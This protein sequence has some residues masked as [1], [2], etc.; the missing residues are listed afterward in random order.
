MVKFSNPYR[1]YAHLRQEASEY[2]IRRREARACRRFW[3]VTAVPEVTL[4]VWILLLGIICLLTHNNDGMSRIGWALSVCTLLIPMLLPH[5]LEREFVVPSGLII[6][7]TERGTVCRGI[8]VTIA[9]LYA[10]LGIWATVVSYSPFIIVGCLFALVLLGLYTYC[11][12]TR[13]FGLSVWG[14]LACSLSP[15]LASYLNMPLSGAVGIAILAFGIVATISG[16]RAFLKPYLDMADAQMDEAGGADPLLLTNEWFSPEE[17][18]RALHSHDADIRYM[19]CDFLCS[20]LEPQAL[21]ALLEAAFDEDSAVAFMA[22][23][24]ITVIWGPDVD[25]LFKMQLEQDLGRSGLFGRQRIVITREQLE[26]INRERLALEKGSEHHEREVENVLRGQV[27]SSESAMDALIRLSLSS[28]TGE[29]RHV[30]IELLGST[31]LHRAYATLIQLILGN[32][33]NRHVVSAAVEGFKGAS[34]SAVVHIEPL[35]SDEREWIRVAAC[36]ASIGLVDTLERVDCADSLLARGMLHDT[37][38]SLARNGKPVT[39]ATIMEL[40]AHYG[41]EAIGTLEHSCEDQF[42]FVRGE[43]VRALTLAGA[44][45]APPH[46]LD[47]LKDSR[48]YVRSCALNCVAYL[49]I[50]EAEDLVASMVDDED[51][52]VALLAK[53]LILLFKT[54]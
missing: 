22:R 31:R 2:A 52:E 44:T 32:G 24:A 27:A 45:C 4:G 43:G 25:A 17:I 47:A 11:G 9:L 33:S 54:W 38:F 21:P 19:T 14:L 23:K 46:V 50:F 3:Y 26:S 48:A 12:Q 36:N 13:L 41:D 51:T 42:A 34:S 1:G 7:T 18:D 5:F 8:T 39:R 49:R 29:V 35:F 37:V 20:Y 15:L 10:L 53:R 6:K 28:D 16:I 30:A 40:L